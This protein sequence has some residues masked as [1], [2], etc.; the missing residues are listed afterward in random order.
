MTERLEPWAREDLP[1]RPFTAAE[2]TH[3]ARGWRYAE[4]VVT[5]EEPAGE[6]VILACR[7]FFRD[8]DAGKWRFEPH[9]AERA[10]RFAS[11][12]PNIKGPLAGKP[13]ELL[14]W[15]AFIWL[16]IF[17]FVDDEGNRRFRQGV[18]Y[19]PRGNGKTTVAAPLA[20]Y[21][22]FIEGEG[23]AEG[24]AA[25]VT[26]DQ[27]R[28]LFDTANAMVQRTAPLRSRFGVE[29][30]A[31]SIYQHRS[32]SSFRP[33]SSD[34]KALDGLNVHVAVCDEIGSHKTSE[35]YDVL[36]T[37]LGKRSQPFLLS[38]STATGNTAGIGRQL[39]GYVARVLRG[40]VEDDRIFG[41]L[42]CAD[43]DDDIWDEETWKKAN[44]SWGVAVQPEAIRAI[45]KQAKESPAREAAFMTRH[46]NIW[47]GAD[48]ALFSLSAWESLAD[49]SLR[50]EYFEGRKCFAALDVSTKIDLAS[51]ILLFPPR[52]GV[53]E[54]WVVFNRS[55]LPEAAVENGSTS[56]YR[57]WCHTVSLLVTEGD[58]TDFD[59]IESVIRDTRDRFDLRAVAFDPWAATQL[60]QRMGAE[61]VNM[62]EFRAT[63][64]NFSE[65]TKELDGFIRSKALAH[66]G[67]PV[68][69]WC[70]GN[71]VGH[72]DARGNVYP[73]KER[74]ENKIDAAIA[75]I[76]A[77]GN[78]LFEEVDKTHVLLNRRGP[79][80]L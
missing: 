79:L 49:E 72:F 69:K 67:D 39:W 53:Q 73:K 3:A 8:I 7:R 4:R 65:P 25:A 10:I 13:L 11:L 50:L 55:F 9:R 19:V 57:E 41:I 70:I 26:R 68:L 22:N 29:A 27:A 66:D 28:I 52:K 23:G 43:P 47:T 64:A 78:A 6:F 1:E 56:S 18:V 33:I 5:G 30:G 45:A 20:L 31:N 38:I 44:P 35:V 34:A 80:V 24:Y 62:V 51:F 21:M 40:S 48:D 59:A 75:L 17:A 16:N 36:L 46:L 32:S 15:Q 37:A 61:G 12:L 74:P 14:D 60:A 63:T 54:P 76:M 71:V 58:V 42:Y 77:L 2:Y